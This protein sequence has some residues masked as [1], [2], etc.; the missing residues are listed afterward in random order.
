MLW[1]SA[2][3][4]QDSIPSEIWSQREKSASRIL[5]R[6]FI[7]AEDL[8]HV[9]YAETKEQPLLQSR[10]L[11]ECVPSQTSSESST[12]ESDPTMFIIVHSKSARSV[13]PKTEIVSY[14]DPDHS[15]SYYKVD[16]A[17]NARVKYQRIDC[18]S[19]VW[20]EGLIM[21]HQDGNLLN[22]VFCGEMQQFYYAADDSFSP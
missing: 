17:G 8:S 16:E 15:V 11:D 21:H 6:P 22:R 4:L 5:P 9:I 14:R 12:E 13:A 7:G 10:P 20:E 19:A 2:C 3:S 1:L 18:S